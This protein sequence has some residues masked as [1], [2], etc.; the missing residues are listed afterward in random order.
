[1]GTACCFSVS[2]PLF[3]LAATIPTLTRI[4]AGY[5]Y[6]QWSSGIPT[7]FIPYQP[8]S[9]VRGRNTAVTTV[10]IFIRSFCWM[11]SWD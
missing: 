3:L 1:M 5:P 8:T 9:R 4:T 6:F 10:K 2:Q 11:D 7:K